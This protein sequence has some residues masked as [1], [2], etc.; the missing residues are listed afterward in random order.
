MVLEKVVPLLEAAGH[1]I[2]TPT[3]TG[4]GERAH[5]LN[6][7]INLSAHL[8]DIV[9]LLEYEDLN[10]VVLVGHS[11]GGMVISGVAEKARTRLSQLVYLDAF[12]PENGKSLRDYVPGAPFDDL[13][14]AKGDGWRLPMEGLVTLEMFGVTDRADVAWMTPRL[15]DQPY[16]TFTEPARLATTVDNS[17]RRAFIQT[18]KFP[19]FVEAAARAKRQGFRYYELL[20]AG[21]DA[22]ITKPK[23]LA[24]I[25]L[26]LV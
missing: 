22:M 23:E 5:L 8:Q 7:Q 17:L 24:K 20:L 2:Y 1:R 12:L 15:G 26:E 25:F 11:Y 19:H 10:N 13:V 3:L 18:S 16:K 14:R 9:A 4:L 21:H 6:P